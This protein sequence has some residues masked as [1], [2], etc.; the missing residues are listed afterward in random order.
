MNSWRFLNEEIQLAEISEASFA[1]PQIIFKHSTT[2]GISAHAEHI[3]GESTTHLA[4]VADLHYLDLLRF[5]SVSNLVADRFSV[6]HQSPQIIVVRNG[7]AIYNSS[8]YS[9]NPA[10][11]L[12]SLN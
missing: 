5:R 10:K 7:K 1:K 3:L 9:I 4:D 11:I 6:P 12:A 8:H 2:C